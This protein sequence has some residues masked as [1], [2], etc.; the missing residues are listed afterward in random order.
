MVGDP[1]SRQRDDKRPYAAF[2]SKLRDLRRPGVSQKE[3]ADHLGTSKSVISRV[4]T[5]KQL[6]ALDLTEAYERHFR[7]PPGLIVAER[8]RI[9]RGTWDPTPA[10]SQDSGGSSENTEPT[11]GID[12]RPRRLR[13]YG[14]AAVAMLV[15]ALAVAVLWATRPS[16]RGCLTIGV[17]NPN[18]SAAFVAVYRAAG[19]EV[20]GCGFSDVHPWGP[21]WIQ[22]LRGGRDGNAAI[23][24][25][26]A[27]QAL[28]LTGRAWHDYQ[29]QLGPNTGPRAGY[30]TSAP[31]RCGRATLFELAGGSEG[32]G[33]MVTLSNSHQFIW[34][35][36]AIWATHRE[37]GGPAGPL[38]SPSGP[39]TITEKGERQAFDGGWIFQPVGSQAAT[40][41]I[42]AD[43][44]T[45]LRC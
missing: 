4:E 42:D 27:N 25:L 30:P 29:A 43:A 32:P 9:V 41:N 7:V 5:G 2:G 14:A 3:L 44:S 34:L 16:A 21:G 23:M 37:L 1:S 31:F 8:D 45:G 28:V 35:S 39:P 36:G 6:P 17:G 18:Y 15:I 33:A 22:D 20:L 26:N 24:A 19:G 12:G 38:G 13:R 10:V 11:S 40:S